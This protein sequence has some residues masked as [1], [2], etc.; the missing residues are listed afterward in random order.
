MIGFTKLRGVKMKKDIKE[1]FEKVFNA[2]IRELDIAM[3]NEED[4]VELSMLICR[5]NK[6]KHGTNAQIQLVLTTDEENFISTGYA[7]VEL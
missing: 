5:Y 1:R 3:D 7:E 2:L 4:P 6:K